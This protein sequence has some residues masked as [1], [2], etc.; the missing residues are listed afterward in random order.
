M[1]SFTV[2]V[3]RCLRV[4][5]RFV[6]ADSGTTGVFDWLDGELPITT[7]CARYCD[8]LSLLGLLVSSWFD[9]KFLV[10]SLTPIC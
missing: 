4:R 1:S 8:I 10:A 9:T 6:V 5:L 3:D 7:V 2:L